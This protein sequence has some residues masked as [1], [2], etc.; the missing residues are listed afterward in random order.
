MPRSAA[1]R[2]KGTPGLTPGLSTT[3]SQSSRSESGWAPH[4]QAADRSASRAATWASGSGRLSVTTTSRPALARCSA[5][6]SPERPAPTTTILP[7]PAPLPSSLAEGWPARP[8]ARIRVPL[9]RK[10][11]HDGQR[12]PPT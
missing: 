5:A 3:S 2:A 12:A 6:A 10:C 11:W 1:A 7:I 9:G 8:P 4:T